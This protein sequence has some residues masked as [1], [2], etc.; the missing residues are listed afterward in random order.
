MNSVMKAVIFCGG[1][2]TR[3]RP[4][5]YKLPKQLLPIN[6]K[7]VLEHSFDLFK[8]Y[9]VNEVLLSVYHL[10]EKIKEYCGD[11]KKFGLRIN[12][13]EEP[14]L[15]GTANHLT[16]AK[17]SLDETF[18]AANGD[19]LKNINL[20][21]M[22]GQH[23]KTGA[24]VTIALK[25]VQDP[26]VYGVV[27]FKGNQILEFVEKPTREE[28]P[29]KFINAGLYIMEPEVFKYIPNHFAML[30]NDVFPV[31]AKEDKLYGYK[32]K[33][34]WFDTGTFERYEEAKIQWKGIHFDN[35]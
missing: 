27:R 28:A 2:G 10:K 6:D 3:L 7:T 29:S 32:F 22:L 18:I 4:L 25:E 21:E 24:L 14:E 9:G 34:Q 13:I 23:R 26:S 16:L 20:E 33:G 11:G 17:S 31:L 1:E 15:L 8:R 12:Y 19:E 35:K 30:E 5:T